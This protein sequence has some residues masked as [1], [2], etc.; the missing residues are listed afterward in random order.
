MHSWLTNRRKERARHRTIKRSAGLLLWT[1]RDKGND[2]RTILSF[3]NFCAFLDPQFFR[4]LHFYQAQDKFDHDKGQK[5]AILG[6]RLHWRLSTGL[7][8]FFP[9]FMCNLVR[10]A[11]QNLEKVAKNS[12]GENRVKSCHVCLGGRFGY[13]LFFSPRG[14]GRGCP[15]RRDGGGRIF[16]G[17]SQEG[18]LPVGGGGGARG[19]EG[20]CGEFGGGG[21]AKYFFSGP[22]CPPSCGCHGF[23]GPDKLVQDRKPQRQQLNCQ[24]PPFQPTLKCHT[25][26]CSH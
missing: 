17:K 24:A 8:A 2:A 18:G 13:F 26:G 9:V 20:V 7:F 12:S 14:R 5:S 25:R 21:G 10:R 23:F 3:I 19:R 16:S 15:R 22:K 4:H 1:C 11:P 6:R